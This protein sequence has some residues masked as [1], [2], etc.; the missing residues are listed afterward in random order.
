[1]ET[2]TGGGNMISERIKAAR[3]GAGYSLRELADKAGVSHTAIS[4]YERGL[5]VPSS[6]VLVRLA[7]AV[8]LKPEYFLRTPQIEMGELCFRKRANLLKKDEKRIYALIHD[9][10]ERYTTVEALAFGESENDRGK[11][12]EKK[13]ATSLGDIENIAHEVREE[14]DL[15]L[16]PIESVVEV[17]EDEGI[18][19]GLFDVSD[20]FDA[21]TFL[22]N[23]R[24]AIAVRKQISGDRRNFS[25]VHELAH[26]LLVAENMDEEKAMHRFAGAFIVPREKVY[27]ELGRKRR[28]IGYEELLLLKRK[29][30]MSMSAW[31][32]RARDLEIITANYY[33]NCMR[34]FSREGW[35]KNEPGQLPT[36]EPTR[37]KQLIYHLL[38]EQQISESRA[39]ELMG[40]SLEEL[41]NSTEE[42]NAP[43]A[44][45]ICN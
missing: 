40:V 4:K 30:K 5:D 34:M 33:Q 44:R 14:W 32:Y 3:Q 19:V 43:S 36:E 27:E 38:A 24:P 35:K 22:V 13:T 20:R 41:L 18:K 8:D 6:A 21:C 10:A 9:W 45:V 7:Q 26:L 1:M 12:S 23:G 37:M 31:L 42:D 17:I 11:L 16:D 39:A 2:G 25:L 15:G 29:Y 28:A